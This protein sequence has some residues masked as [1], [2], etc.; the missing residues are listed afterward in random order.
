MIFDL[1]RFKLVNDT[2]G[3]V[4]GDAVLREFAR[5]MNGAI[6][7]TDFCARYGGEEFGM[8]TVASSKASQLGERV[9]QAMKELPFSIAD[10][11][12]V[13]A[14]CSYG[15]AVFPFDAVNGEDLLKKADS[16]LYRAKE[17]GRDRGCKFSEGGETDCS[18]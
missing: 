5:R 13:D 7:G 15:Y 14:T 12:P 2:Y 6:R 1:D 18:V 17:S 8:L 9:R 3:H 11:E 4:A 16:A 10:H